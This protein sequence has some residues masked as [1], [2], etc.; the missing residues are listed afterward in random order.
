MGRS[1]GPILDQLVDLVLKGGA[2]N[3]LALGVQLWAHL[4]STRE[5]PALLASA[6]L[7]GEIWGQPVLVL[8]DVLSL[9]FL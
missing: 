7:V 5:C 9:I 8:R 4:G 2:H 6:I 1:S 3:I